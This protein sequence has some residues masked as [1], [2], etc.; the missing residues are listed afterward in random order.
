LA[1]SVALLAAG[2]GIENEQRLNAQRTENGIVGKSRHPPR[3][4][5]QRRGTR[6]AQLVRS[7]MA[8]CAQNDLAPPGRGSIKTMAYELVFTPK[9]GRFASKFKVLWAI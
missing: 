9:I 2:C 8:Q 4:N 5:P 7:R 6:G 3:R 1:A